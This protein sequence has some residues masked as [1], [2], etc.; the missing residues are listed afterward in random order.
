[1]AVVATIGI[2][3]A[4]LLPVLGKAQAKAQQ[5]Y[6]LSNLHQLG[7]A[8][9]LYQED[10]NG[11]LAESYTTNNPSAWVQGNM[12]NA[13]DAVNAALVSQGK[14][15][16]YNPAVAIYRCPTD[17]GVQIGG[18]TVQNTRSYSESCFMG[19]RLATIGPVPISAA[20]TSP[21]APLGYVQSFTCGADLQQPSRLFVF[22]DESDQTLGTGCFVTDP[23]G[24]V[25]Y[26]YP[27]AGV[28]RHYQ[29]SIL[30]FADGHAESWATRDPRTTTPNQTQTEQPDNA[31]LARFAAS[32]TL[33]R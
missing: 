29:S 28:S 30:N 12:K 6:C 23:T 8:W 19:T 31:D 22:V 15:F 20:A 4:L 21:N 10:N 25:W 9:A 33:P 7:I 18:Q 3:A 14:L 13:A 5:A 24:H 17:K 27:A 1:L 32:A 2:L 26:D 11:M 16:P